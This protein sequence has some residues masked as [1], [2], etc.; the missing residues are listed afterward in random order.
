MVNE[1]AR[2]TVKVRL[3]D[4]LTEKNKGKLLPNLFK[5]TGGEFTQILGQS[6]FYR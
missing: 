4:N 3:P 1:N 5:E 2:L 6:H